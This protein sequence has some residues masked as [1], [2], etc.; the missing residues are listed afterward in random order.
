M[1]SVSKK[2]E[3]GGRYNTENIRE[4]FTQDLFEKR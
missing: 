1:I 4:N 3:T 2:N